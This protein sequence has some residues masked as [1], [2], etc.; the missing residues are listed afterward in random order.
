MDDITA[1][2]LKENK[3]ENKINFNIYENEHKKEPNP[4][5]HTNPVAMPVLGRVMLNPLQ[6]R[7]SLDFFSITRL[8]IKRCSLWALKSSPLH[9]DSLMVRESQKRREG[10]KIE[11]YI[12]RV[13]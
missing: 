1:T 6:S 2:I 3:N 11:F 9:F 13:F 7:S 8:S 10:E 12:E 5:F 4:D